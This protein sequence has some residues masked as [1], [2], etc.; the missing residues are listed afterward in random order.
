MGC[1]CGKRKK[2]KPKIITQK[3]KTAIKKS[4]PKCSKPMN[5]KQVFSPKLRRY[6][7][8]WDCTICSYKTQ[9]L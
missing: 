6:I 2:D 5:Y 7:K 8:V 1:G 3:A 9:S 4:C